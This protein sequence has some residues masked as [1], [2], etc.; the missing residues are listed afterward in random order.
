MH[1]LA[2]HYSSSFSSSF[3]SSLSGTGAAG[4]LSG[5]LI[6]AGCKTMRGVDIVSSL[7]ELEEKVER[8][9]VVFSGEGSYDSQT[10]E[11]K[12]VSEVLF[13]SCVSKTNKQKKS[14][15]ELSPLTNSL[16]GPKAVQKAQQAACVDLWKIRRS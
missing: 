6:A 14:V 16:I 12:T 7:L 11:G 9:D 3:S 4:G 13:L 10:A 5:G 2:S 15:H 1:L 8:S